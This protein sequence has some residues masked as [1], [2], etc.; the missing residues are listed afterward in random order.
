MEFDVVIVGGGP[1]GLAAGIR[2]R[3]LAAQNNREISVCV[4][5]KASEVGA[6]TLAGAVFETRALD[7]LLPDWQ[8]DDT[9]PVKTAVTKDSFCFLTQK[10]S[11]RLPTPPQMHNDGNYI[12]S[13]GRVVQWLGAKAEAAGVE[14]FP[15]FAAAEILYDDAGTVIGVATGDMGVGKDGERTANYQPGVELHATYTVFA[16]G[17]RGSLSE[18][19]IARFNLRE[20]ASPQTY[21]IGIK[22][23]WETDRARPGEVVHT[24]GYP[25]D[26]STYGGSFLYH[27]EEGKVAV[28]FV[29]GLDYTN[30]Y[31]SPYEEFQR[32]KHHPS[33]AAVL[34]GGRR[35]GYGARAL[36]EGGWQSIPTLAVPGAVLVGCAAGFLNVAKIKGAHTAMKSGMLA[37][38]AIAAAFDREGK[39]DKDAQGAIL[40][41]YE[42]ALRGSWV[43][44]ELKKVR[45]IRPGFRYGLWA[46]LA[47][48]A[49]DTYLLRGC[50]PW[51]FQHHADHTQLRPARDCQPIAYPKP[52]GVLSFSRLEN[53]SFSGVFHEDNQPAHLQLRDA[54]KPVAVNLA[55]YDGPEARFC[56]AGVYEF[57][58][59]PEGEKT[60]MINAQNC[61]HCKTCDIKDPTQN[62]HWVTPEGGGGPRY[63]SM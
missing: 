30:P 11:Y 36:N 35:I 49:V 41:D 22:E 53:L 10:K 28:G 19:L 32:F 5:E 48:A 57:I 29:V 7:E 50:A 6:H 15:G 31:L 33:I 14:I 23:L 42:T 39:D 54:Q 46:G 12:I 61:V 44:S 58:D 40:T 52:D 62:I 3:Q 59:T 18:Q 56:P 43:A 38:D 63:E 4:L 60:L 17:C 27:L 20:S 16:E 8:T 45:N 2:L 55:V 21:G 1:A 24:I 51:T 26:R 9:A 37:A 47:H 34:R 13:L 25:L